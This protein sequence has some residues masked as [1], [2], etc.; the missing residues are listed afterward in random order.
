LDFDG[1]NDFVRFGTTYPQNTLQ[2][3]SVVVWQRGIVSF[4]RWRRLLSGGWILASIEISGTQR[5]GFGYIDSS[6][7]GTWSYTNQSHDTTS[8][9]CFVGTADGSG[10][11]GGFRSYL[12]GFELGA[13]TTVGTT[14][15]A[16]DA[17][18]SLQFAGTD[19]TS[20]FVSAVLHEC[21]IYNRV[22]S[23][24][25]IRLLASRP[26]IAYEL[27]PRTTY[28]I[29]KPTPPKRIVV[30]AKQEA[31]P[32]PPSYHNG[33]AP[34][35]GEPL[36][37][38]LWDGCVGAWN[39]GLGSTGTRLYDWSPY[40]NHGT[41]TNMGAATAWTRS[42]GRNA[43]SF[44]GG[45]THV[46]TSFIGPAVN[47]RSL[48]VWFRTTQNHADGQYG[49]IFFYGTGTTFPAGLGSS[50]FVMI[51]TETMNGWNNGFGVSQFGES[52]AVNNVNDGLWHHGCIVNSGTTYRVWLDG[53]LRATKTMATTPTSSAAFLG[54][55]NISG[56]LGSNLNY[57]GEADDYAFYN[58]ALSHNEIRLLASRRGI[59]YEMAPRNWSAQQI[60]AYRARYYSQVVGGGVI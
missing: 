10:T 51:F 50:F 21:S 26:G 12:N 37:P 55:A 13:K 48:S 57:V 60:A 23:P 11:I 58:R 36:F 20:T 44:A 28:S 34:R 29:P 31:T 25:E 35:D 47:Q 27:K 49:T 54:R 8:L 46:V 59:A 53:T 32:A 40:K 38:E 2:P 1:V 18:A 19:G 42:N 33:F 17:S 16:I 4:S 24:S 9:N 52:L 5:V 22:L 43:L 39:P 6:G 41:M 7:G 45:A 3:F 56:S 30:K 14:P 15:V